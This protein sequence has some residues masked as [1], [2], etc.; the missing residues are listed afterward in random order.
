M[1]KEQKKQVFIFGIVA[2]LGISL[3]TPVAKAALNIEGISMCSQK[4]H[5]D[6]TA[7]S[8]PWRFEVNIYLGDP[9]TLDHIDVTLPTGGMTPFTIYEDSGDWEYHSSPTL[10]PTLTALQDVYP[11]GTYTFDFRDISDE[12]LNY[13]ELNYSDIGNP[14]SPVDFT[15]PSYNGQTGISTNPTLTWTIDSGAG[16]VLG[17]AF[18]ADDDYIYNNVLGA[19][20]TLSWQPGPLDPVQ[21]YWLYVT[22]VRIKDWA[23]GPGLPTMTVGG[24]EFEY[25]LHIGYMNKIGF[26]TADVGAIVDIV[27]TITT[28]TKWIDCYLWLPGYDVA[29]IDLDSIRLGGSISAVRA[30]V[31]KKQQMLVVKFSA[32]EL[33]LDPRPEPYSLTVSGEL[34]GGT[35]FACSDDITVIQKGGKKN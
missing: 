7:P 31:R 23:G 13:V 20:E 2:I 17:M 6:G 16:D 33:N 8:N 29:D 1:F 4:D 32:S 27:D 21:N 9:G 28:K 18:K 26:T 34:N 10:Y 15:Y 24:D 25:V 5:L 12:Q 30:S 35:T 19:M 14:G 11:T 22:V 3:A